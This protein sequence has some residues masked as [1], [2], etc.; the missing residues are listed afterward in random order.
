MSSIPT[1]RSPTLGSVI[2]K[3]TLARADP[4]IAL[5]IKLLV[6][7]LIFAPKS[8]TIDSPL[9]FGQIDAIEGLLILATVRNFSSE[10]AIRAPVLPHDKIAFDLPLTT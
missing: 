6:S 7:F 3:S 10:I 1:L 9:I 4:R 8:R 5:S 2:L